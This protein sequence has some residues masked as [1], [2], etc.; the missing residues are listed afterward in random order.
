MGIIINYDK[1]KE[2]NSYLD[3]AISFL[4]KANKNINY[5]NRLYSKESINLNNAVDI[6]NDLKNSFTNFCNDYEETERAIKETINHGVLGRESNNYVYGLNDDHKEYIASNPLW[7]HQQKN[8]EQLNR[9]KIFFEQ[10]TSEGHFD[11]FYGADQNAT[12]KWADVR[13][14]YVYSRTQQKK[15]TD[16]YEFNADELYEFL[17]SRGYEEYYRDFM[18]GSLVLDESVSSDVLGV[19]D[20]FFYDIYGPITYKLFSYSATPS[21]EVSSITFYP[22]G[23]RLL[24]KLINTYGFSEEDAIKTYEII[25]TVGICTYAS[26]ANGIFVTFQ[27]K[28]ELFEE[29]FGFPMTITIDGVERLNSSELL[30]DMY[31]YINTSTF[32]YEYGDLFEYN[33]GKYSLSDYDILD[34]DEGGLYYLNASDIKALDNYLKSKNS[35]LYLEQP[36]D[37]RPSNGHSQVCYLDYDFNKDVYHYVGDDENTAEVLAK[38]VN[39]ALSNNRLLTLE[40]NDSLAEVSMLD[41]NNNVVYSTF[42]VED[43]GHSVMV[44]GVYE[45]GIYVASWGKEDRIEYST[46]VEAGYTLMAWNIG[47]IN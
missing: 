33:D 34:E 13:Y 12:L 3:N 43:F 6:I 28:E 45:T 27:G 30:L 42:K 5:G 7:A 4:N 2:C 16:Y 44:T 47:G 15:P 11:S 17:K 1:F 18:D 19:I 41:V 40:Y 35:G 23:E 25:D 46:L 39:E 37:M 38:S 20:E 31:V 29:I 36:R 22:E 10:Y 21:N 9:A 14:V 24:N 26:A 8:L 32:G